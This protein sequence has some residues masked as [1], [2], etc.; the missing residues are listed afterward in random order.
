MS[1]AIFLSASVPD[2]K[3]S[4]E[5][6]RTADTVAI[7][8]AVSALVYVTLG[9]RLLV[10]GGHPAITPM[11]LVV[12][13]EM[14]IDYGSW[15][16]LYQSNYF[17]EEFPEDNLRFQNVRHTEAIGDREKSLRLMREQMFSEQPFDAGVFIGGCW[18]N[19]PYSESFNQ[20]RWPCRCFQQEGQCWNSGA[21]FLR[22][23]NPSSPTTSTTLLC[24]TDVLTFL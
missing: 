5:F 15:V 10:W 16:K 8:A 4:P 22:H 24:F 12:A 3:R 18:M 21:R 17:A 11:I 20:I 13:E 19:M 2:P 1:G 9:R 7:T 6:A 14:G 23:R